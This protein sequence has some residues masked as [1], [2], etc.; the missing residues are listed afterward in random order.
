MNSF[1]VPV[2]IILVFLR[3][4]DSPAFSLSSFSFFS[5]FSMHS[6][7]LANIVVSSAYNKL[8]MVLPPIFIPML[9]SN[10]TFLIIYSLYMLNK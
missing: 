10:P 3:F 6:F 7:S 2:V 1:S 4:S 8:F 9:S 5:S